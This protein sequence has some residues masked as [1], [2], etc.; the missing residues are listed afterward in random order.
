M[1]TTCRNQRSF[2]DKLRLKLSKDYEVIESP[3]IGTMLIEVAFMH[4]EECSPA[5]I[6]WSSAAYE[7]QA[8]VYSTD[9]LERWDHTFGR[10]T[11]N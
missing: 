10:S 6:L 4:L 9:R 7:L 3:I 11:W 1:T 8:V 5:P 2:E